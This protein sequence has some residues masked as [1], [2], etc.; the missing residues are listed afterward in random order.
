MIIH[1]NKL[2]PLSTQNKHLY[3]ISQHLGIVKKI[4][5]GYII[6]NVTSTTNS[7]NL[8]G[9]T[10]STKPCLI[11]SSFRY[12]TAPIFIDEN[13]FNEYFELDYGLEYMNMLAENKTQTTKENIKELVFNFEKI[14]LSTIK[15]DP[16]NHTHEILAFKKEYITN[17]RVSYVDTYHISEIN[18]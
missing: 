1:E 3:Y 10:I 11:G 6:S 15:I 16:I 8:G 14:F 2:Y 5:N 13:L 7:I 18:N 17:I 12:M 9:N 4:S